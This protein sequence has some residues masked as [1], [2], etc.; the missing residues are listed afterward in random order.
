MTTRRTSTLVRECNFTRDAA[1]PKEQVE[2]NDRQKAR[3]QKPNGDKPFHSMEPIPSPGGWQC[4]WFRALGLG[5]AEVPLQSASR[6]SIAGINGQ[7]TRPLWLGRQHPMD[8]DRQ[9]GYRHQAENRPQPHFCAAETVPSQFPLGGHLN[10]S[11]QALRAF[12]FWCTEI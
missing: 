9:Q 11:S 8:A 3:H 2:R 12:S 6:Q 7:V 5:S 4:L 1:F 10:Q